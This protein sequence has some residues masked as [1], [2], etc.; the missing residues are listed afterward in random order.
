MIITNGIRV[1]LLTIGRSH[2]N[3]KTIRT[4]DIMTPR[5]RAKL[6]TYLHKYCDISSIAHVRDTLSPDSPAKPGNDG[7]YLQSFRPPSRNPVRT[8]L[9]MLI[10]G[11]Y[12]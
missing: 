8:L 7:I 1:F 9:E 6:S 2:V 5:G 10:L 4:L 3:Q 12:S 11:R